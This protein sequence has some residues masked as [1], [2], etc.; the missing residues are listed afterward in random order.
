MF[1]GSKTAKNLQ[2]GEA[3]PPLLGFA[4]GKSIVEYLDNK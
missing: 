1:F 3:V 2:I 4:L